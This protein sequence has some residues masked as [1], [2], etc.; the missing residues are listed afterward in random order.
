MRPKPMFPR[1]LSRE[2]Y[3]LSAILEVVAEGAQV[4]R[5]RRGSVPVGTGTLFHMKHCK[6]RPG[7]QCDL[8]SV[9]EGDFAGVGR[10]DG[11]KLNS[12]LV[13]SRR[14]L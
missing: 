1:I 13:P 3:S 12:N 9:R 4:A 14:L 7:H 2:L 8:P 6:F 10:S 5:A 11:W